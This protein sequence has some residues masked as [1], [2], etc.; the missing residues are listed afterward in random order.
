MTPRLIVLTGG[1]GAGKTAVLELARKTFCKHIVHL[2]EAASIVFG[3]GF[4]RE[5]TAIGKKAGQV[6]IFHIGRQLERLALDKK[7][8]IVVLCDRGSL[9]GLAYWPGTEQA[10]FEEMGTTREKELKRYYRILH[11]RTP[12]IEIG[13]NHSNPLRIESAAEA[14]AIDEKIINAWKGHPNY[15]VV[16][17]TLDFLE[18]AEKALSILRAEIGEC[19]SHQA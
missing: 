12:A 13:Y 14:A 1:P 17:G 10:F 19:P 3:G 18:K 2:P 7:E 8:A 16:N 6:A 15:K 4:W 5:Q 11:L 9:D